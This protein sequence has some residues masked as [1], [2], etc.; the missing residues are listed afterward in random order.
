MRSRSSRKISY[1]TV[2]LFSVAVLL[3]IGG[4]A[5][6]IEP[7]RAVWESW[8]L[9]RVVTFCVSTAPIAVPLLS[10][11]LIIINL[12][13]HRLE[14]PSV[15]NAVHGILDEM[16]RIAFAHLSHLPEH[17]RRVTLFNHVWWHWTLLG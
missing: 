14:V 11:A 6:F 16:Q 5:I 15:L 2:F 4:Y 13:L 12:W 7:L 9:G 17:E 3:V 10:L 8:H 1:W